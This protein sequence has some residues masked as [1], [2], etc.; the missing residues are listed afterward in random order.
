MIEVYSGTPGS[1][2]SLH[3]AHVIR[4]YLRLGKRVISTCDIDTDLCFLNPFR[5]FWINRTG[6]KPKRIKRNKKADNFTY[7]DIN[8]VKPDFLYQYALQL[9]F[10]KIQSFGTSGTHFFGS[11]GTSVMMWFLSLRVRSS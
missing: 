3:I 1:G 10:P 5:V 8:E 7:I 9:S 11:I 6:K 4:N 2:K